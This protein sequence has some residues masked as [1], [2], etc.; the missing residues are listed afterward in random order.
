MLRPLRVALSLIAAGADAQQVHVVAPAGTPGGELHLR[1]PVLPTVLPTG[2][3]ALT[4]SDQFVSAAAGG[5]GVLS[6]PSVLE[7]MADVP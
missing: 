4:I 1:A 3:K 5:G 2:L 6:S 7:P